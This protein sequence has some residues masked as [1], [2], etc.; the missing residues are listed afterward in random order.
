MIVPDGLKNPPQQFTNMS[1]I[2]RSLISKMAGGYCLTRRTFLPGLMPVP[3]VHFRTSGWRSIT[4]STLWLKTGREH[5][6][7]CYIPFLNQLYTVL[8]L[9]RNLADKLYYSCLFAYHLDS[10]M[11]IYFKEDKPGISPS[12]VPFLVSILYR[13]SVTL[14]RIPVTC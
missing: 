7:H 3:K 1:L 10:R 12:G 4:I 9:S 5:S 8:F 11:L 13:L 14:S 2:S 6:L